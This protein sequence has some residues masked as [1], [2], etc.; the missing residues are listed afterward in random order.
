MF[1]KRVPGSKILRKWS[2]LPVGELSTTSARQ[3]VLWQDPCKSVFH[4]YWTTKPYFLVPSVNPLGNWEDSC[5]V[6]ALHS[7][8]ERQRWQRAAQERRASRPWKVRGLW[9]VQ[10]RGRLLSS[11]GE[12]AQVA[13]SEAPQMQPCHPWCQWWSERTDPA[14]SSC[15][16]DDAETQEATK[17]AWVTAKSVTS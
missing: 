16:C 14:A 9:Q 15:S 7:D 6:T 1:F 2:Q 13:A 5:S 12:A 10:K 8:Q 4:S 17:R 3:K 11:F